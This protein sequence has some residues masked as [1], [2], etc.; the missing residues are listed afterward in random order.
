MS[1]KKRLLMAIVMM[2]SAIALYAQGS[3]GNRI[4]GTILDENGE[5]IVGA[6]VI[7]AGTQNAVVTDIDGNF[8]LS[9]KSGSTL[10]VSYVGYVSQTLKATSGKPMSIT[11]IEDTESL[12][13]I[14]VV[15]YGTQKKATLSGSV[16]SVRGKELT[17]SPTLNVSQSINGRLPGV[18]ALSQTSEPGYDG[19]AIR[20]RGVNTFGNANPL[21]V[22]DG[23]P[24]RSLERIDPNT[25]ESMS[26]LKD[27]SAAI[28]GAQAANG[29]IIITTKRGKKERPVVDFSYNYGLSRPTVIPEMCDAAEYATLLNEID[30]YAG[31]TPRY[32]EEDIQKFGDGSDPWGHPNTDWF[33]EVLKP[34]SPQ[35]MLNA[36]ISGGS[37]R[38]K[39][40]IGMSVKDQDGLYRHSATR[41]KQYDLRSNLDINLA[42]GLDFYLNLSGRYEDR[43]YGNRSAADIF[44]ITMRSKPTMPAF[45]PNG[46]PGPDIEFGDNAVV[47][48]TSATGYQKDKRYV[49]NGDMGLNIQIP[50]VEGLSLKLNASI[51]ETIRFDKN[52]KIPWYL[53]S[54]NGGYDE[55]GEPVLQQNKVGVEDP[56]LWQ[57][58]NNYYNILLSAIANYNR[59]FGGVHDVNITAGV[60]RIKSRTMYF[61]AFRRYFISPALDE[62]FAGGE[63]EKTNSGW[64][65]REARLNYF[66]RFNYAYK[67]R[68]LAELIW[69]Y[70]GSYIFDESN[71]FG[72]FP[73]V[74]LGYVLSEENYFKNLLPWVHYAKLRGSWGQTGNDLI[75]PYQYLA[76]YSFGGLMY[77][78]NGGQSLDKALS[79]NVVPNKNVSWETATQMNVGVD[80]QFLRGDLSVTFDWFKNTRKD[81]LWRRNVSIPS[82]TGMSLPYENL[83]EVRNSGFDFDVN[84]HHSIGDFFWSVGVNGVYARNKILF[85]DEAE[86]AP[87][88]QKSTGMPIGCGLV[89]KAI[90]VFKD[91]E[92]LANTPHWPGARPGDVIFADI[93]G[94][95]VIDGNDMFRYDKS[96]TPR[97]T[98]GITLSAQWKGLDLSML[99]QGAM[100]AAF[101]YSTESGDFGNFLKSYYDGRWTAENPSATHPRTYNRT[102]EYWVNQSNTYWIHS[103]D[104]IRLKNIELGYTLPDKWTKAVRLQKVRLYTNAFNLLT[105]APC[106]KDYDPELQNGRGYVHPISKVINF[107]ASV[108]F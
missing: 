20:I 3:A 83:G 80:L 77:I 75:D 108:T 19:T 54:W 44:R 74:S 2:M 65:S 52:F 82:T 47:M 28:Y 42:K 87:D 71:H 86:G 90:G 25:I 70:Q 1:M 106:M 93:D 78:S 32:T 17:K 73:G 69:R 62:L 58:A 91:E 95:D 107:G 41:Y 100:G 11:M 10:N 104:Y 102:N 51:D 14:V 23:V 96:S 16:S 21:I 56:Q 63:D 68:Y 64:N 39:Y 81:I 6:T 34:W 76:S 59:T 79:E 99:W 94:N 101:M 89:Y 31:I 72:F 24:G 29:V 46:L 84:Y 53:Y 26:V 27:A 36:T 50:G 97:F 37:D 30:T 4:S 66:G 35:Q 12:N 57:D 60:E 88:W 45:Y 18:F 33:K 55:S 7:E 85:W 48:G 38:V 61:E 98:Y 67:Q 40:F 92:Q 103:N 8:S 9:V 13:E 105:Y 43:H 15:G 49:L 22:V 5:P